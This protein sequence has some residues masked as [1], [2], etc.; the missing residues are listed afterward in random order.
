MRNIAVTKVAVIN[1]APL[2]VIGGSHLRRRRF[3]FLRAE[4][5]SD[6][7]EFSRAERRNRFGVGISALRKY[8]SHT[9]FI[10]Y[11]TYLS[12]KPLDKWLAM[13]ME[14]WVCYSTH[15]AGLGEDAFSCN[16]YEVTRV[17]LN[18]VTF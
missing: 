7:A 14:T 13:E 2:T 9:N 17:I 5:R 18:L 16:S 10:C 8:L 3:G 15:L 6:R 4:F 12:N 11:I 1:P